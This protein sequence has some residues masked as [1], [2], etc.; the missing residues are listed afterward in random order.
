MLMA[1]EFEFINQIK[2][3]FSL[4]KIGD[5]CAVLPKNETH[6]LVITTDLI[7]EDIDFKLDWATAES[8][9]HKALAVSLSDI[10]AMGAKPV[11]A[12]LSIGLPTKIWNS[13]FADRFY[14]SWF[15]LAKKHQIEL[16]G[17]DIS[18][19]PDKIVID[20]IVAGEVKKGKAILRSKAKVGD[21]IFVTGSLGGA[22]VG[23]MM[24]EGQDFYRKNNPSILNPKSFEKLRNR[25]LLPN[26]RVEVGQN[27]AKFAT[28]MID[29]S[30]GLSS[31]LTHIC[32]ASQVGA[33]IFKEKIPVNK[34]ID[35]QHFDA[36]SFALNG[37]EDFELLFTVNPK[38]NFEKI[39]RH[40]FCIG[41]VTANAG[42][43]ELISDEKP[44]VLDPKGYQHF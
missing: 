9:G 38:K 23:L 18:K 37:G 10:A 4:D 28:S 36:F 30:D 35:E 3:K 13:D 19:T 20:S 39:L 2:Q 14:K 27:L 32:E 40:F 22:G 1:K 24:L 44:T 31:D 12:M 16:V 11:W 33:K 17:G 5:D 41:E 34:F 29:I 25:Q 15:K 21:S 42:I 26:P 6:D 8:I 7:I 43:I